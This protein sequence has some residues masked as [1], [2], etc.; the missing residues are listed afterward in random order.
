MVLAPRRLSWL[1]AAAVSLLLVSGCGNPAARSFVKVDSPALAFTHVRVIDGMGA[2][3]RD[4]QTVLVLGG[5]IRA[6]GNAAAV[7]TPAGAYVIDGRGR[8]LIPGLVG[9]H[10]HLFYETENEH[11]YRSQ[12]AFARLYL[13]A[14]VTT[15][16]TTGAVDFGG[17]L[18]LKRDVDAGRLPGPDIDL[19]SAYLNAP[20]G[21][22][23]PDFMRRQVDKYADRGAT[24][25]KAYMSVRGSE[26]KAAIDEAHA[27]GARITGHLCAVGFEDAI[28]MGI[29]NLEHGIVVDTDLEPNKQPDVCP[30][31]LANVTRLSETDIA[32]DP[33]IHELISDLVNHGV[34]VTSTLAIFESF[35]DDARTADPRVEMML[36]PRLHG[37][38]ETARGRYMNPEARGPRIWAAAL[39]REMQFEHAFVKA[40]GKLMAGVDPTGWGGVLAGF[41]D[42]RELELLVMAGF[43]SEEAIKIASYNGAEFEYATDRVGSIQEGRQ[44]DLVLVRGNPSKRISDVRNVEMVF[45]DGVG[46]D[47]DALIAASR[48]TVGQYDFSPVLRFPTNVILLALTALLVGRVLTKRSARQRKTL[49]PTSMPVSS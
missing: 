19:T 33:A 11:V 46:Y 1:R 28:R 9:M 40:G 17:D 21:P 35:T 39:W 48:G 43:T 18:Q 34:A 45:K 29:D 5:K 44:A 3:S 37:S 49:Q 20:S 30:Q 27:R 15:I 8:T 10:D 6:V 14:G 31:D 42:Q 26:L 4:D 32:T 25:F 16:R 23:D 2:R 22:P 41:G 36:A 24:S 12:A 7:H 38:Y 13:A 47:P